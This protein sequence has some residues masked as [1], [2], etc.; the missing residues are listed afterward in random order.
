MHGKQT[1]TS[2]WE[3]AVGSQH[4]DTAGVPGRTTLTSQLSAGP[5]APIQRRAAQAGA[6]GTGSAIAGW[7]TTFQPDLAAAPIQRKA[8]G[9]T[10]EA[11]APASGGGVPMPADLRAKMERAFGADFSAVRIHQGPQARALGALAYTQGTDI[12]F[13]PGQYDPTSTAGQELLGHELTHVVQ[14]TQGRVAAS[15]QMKGIGLNDD[16]ALEREADQLGARAARGEAV[17]GGA[18]TLGVTAT[19]AGPVQRNKTTDERNIPVQTDGNCGL[20][21]ILTALR[22]FGFGGGVQDKAIS[23]MDRMT[24]QSEETFLGEIFTIDLMLKIINELEVDGKR[25]LKAA[26]AEFSTQE[27]LELLLAKLKKNNDVTVLVGYSKPDEYDDYYKTRGEFLAGKAKESQV[28]KDLDK[29]VKVENFK[30]QHG[31]W[32]MINE[33]SD[34]GFLDISDSLG[35]FRPDRDHGYNTLMSTRKL[36]NSN[37]SLSKG[38]FDWTNFLP[39]DGTDDLTY[40]RMT[41]GKNTKDLSKNERYQDI[42]KNNNKEKL[43]LS[44][45]LVVVEV[46]ELGKAML[47][48]K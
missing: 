30:A 43:D 10:G 21:S 37:M 8:G 35:K 18:A 44:G 32:G 36:F 1:R 48:G 33:I 5:A 24:K 25:I 20:F 16:A 17:H 40:N 22:T 27:E 38:E 28:E 6:P 34:D 14:Q 7:M 42:R 39:S 23:A 9:E 26:P 12:H 4:A 15:R 29:K 46:T 31:H 2:S 11:P 47:Q 19:S 45:R 41:G 3:P 13:A